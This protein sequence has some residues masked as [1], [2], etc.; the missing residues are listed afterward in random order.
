MRKNQACFTVRVAT[1][2]VQGALLGLA[3]LPA[4]YADDAASPSVADLVK[5]GSHIEL[6]V[7]YVS[8]DSFK[9][10]EY[11]GLDK[12]GTYAIGNIDLRGGGAYDGDSAMRYRINGTNLGL[13]T[14]NLTAEY[15]QQGLF[16]LIYGHDE[17]K[18]NYSDSYKTL[19]D[20]AGGSTLT[21]PAEYPP[22]ATRVSSTASANEALANWNNIQAPYATAACAAAGGT[23]AGACRGP[24]ILIPALM[25]N[26]DVETK[27]T[28]DGLAFSMQFSPGWEMKA[29]VRHEE[30][31]GTKLTGVNMN[32]FS[33]PS[34]LLPE[35]IDSTTDLYEATV[36]YANE[37]GH[38]SVGYNG[39]FYNNDI[40]VWS[41][42]Y[43][44]AGSTTPVP[45]NV[46]HMSG[47]PDNHM[48]QI[49]L[50]GGYNFTDTIKLVMS[51]AYTRMLQDESFLATPTGATWVL[52]ETSAHAKVVN[53]FFSAK[54]TTR[55]MMN[56]GLNFGYKYDNRD[57]Q[58]PIRD[59]LVTPDLA[60]ASTQFTNEPINRRLQQINV[61][62]DYAFAGSQGINVGYEWQEIERTANGEESPFRAKKTWENTLGAEYRNNLLD[63]L[64]GR[65]AY[66][67]SQRRASTYED[68][69]P[70]PVK[71]AAPLPA[72][73]PLLPGFRQFFLADRNR[74]KLRGSLNYQVTDAFAL[75]TGLSY[76][77]DDYNHS[78]YGLQESRSWALNLDGD[79]AVSEKLSFNAYYTYEDMKSRLDSYAIAR[80]A[81]TTIL[82]PHTA[83]AAFSAPA[84]HQPADYFQ[85]D[86]CRQWSETQADRIHTLGLGFKSKGMLGGKLELTGDLAYSYARTP[87]DVSG[88]SYY[89][90]GA[91][92]LNNVFV[93][94]QSFPDI[95]SR[96]TDVKLDGVYKLDKSSSIR[97]NYLYRHLTT[98]DWQYDA[99]SSSALGVIAVQGYVGPGITSPDYS[100]HILGVS[101]IY[102]FK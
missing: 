8:D 26:F 49:N 30:K 56:L 74:D 7:G 22:A 41:A 94:A 65:L 33:G 38:F 13:D 72:A 52:P 89:S 19:W 53:T 28:I 90:N 37:R 32:R 93:P 23:P 57:N 64:T 86:P 85:G 96:M 77:K 83:C 48:H 10:G 47:V 16:R 44:G 4:A 68:G 99:Y 100:V 15:G 60:G 67:Y 40:D 55:P 95:T 63:N 43:A 102:S 6:G 80:A 12:Q 51:G 69:D 24:G 45:G 11:N 70:A 2:A 73:G 87:I 75:Q 42:Q 25:K 62:A 39:S 81:S 46:A 21:L 3:V 31:S 98:R 36:G 58:T 54:L 17:I 88:G 84:G 66:A 76:S 20:G 79:Y 1:A 92:A 14:R 9:Q 61:D 34:A 5:P 97:M 82:D 101:Y 35:P 91:A 18:R 50:A 59:F 29:S 78:K 27:R 71:P